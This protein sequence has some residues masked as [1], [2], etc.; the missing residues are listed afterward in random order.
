MVCAWEG[1]HPSIS[2]TGQGGRQLRHSMA[3]SL[4]VVKKRALG[5]KPQGKGVRSST[6][7]G[8]FHLR[9][10]S[11]PGKQPTFGIAM[12]MQFSTPPLAS[13]CGCGSAPHLWHCYVDAVQHIADALAGHFHLHTEVEQPLACNLREGKGRS[14]VSASVCTFTKLPV[15]RCAALFEFLAIAPAMTRI[16]AGTHKATHIRHTHTHAHTR[17]GPRHAHTH[18]HVRSQHSRAW[19]P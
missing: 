6:C 2:R 18:T 11:P 15:W 17:P 16:H 14:C 5:T 3:C 13:L 8:T 7:A 19:P 10:L 1:S 4:P 9:P 12:W